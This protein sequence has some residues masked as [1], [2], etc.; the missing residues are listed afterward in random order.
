MGTTLAD[1]LPFVDKE[2]KDRHRA[3]TSPGNSQAFVFLICIP[4]CSSFRAAPASKLPGFLGAL[5]CLLSPPFK[6]LSVSLGSRH[7]LLYLNCVP[8]NAMGFFLKGGRGLWRRDAGSG[9]SFPP[10]FTYWE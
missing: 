6:S 4:I 5:P 3:C 2:T 1:A 8:P 9:T 7:N 10:Q